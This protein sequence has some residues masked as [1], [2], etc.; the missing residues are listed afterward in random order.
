MKGV[1]DCH[2]EES[3]SG[4][5]QFPIIALNQS[6]GFGGKSQAGSA[7]ARPTPSGSGDG[8]MMREDNDVGE[9]AQRC[10][11]GLSVGN[12]KQ[13]HQTLPLIRSWQQRRL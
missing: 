2:P 13:L 12:A 3:G 10:A 6:S 1:Q 11:V 7:L 9:I 4:C 5:Q 8:P